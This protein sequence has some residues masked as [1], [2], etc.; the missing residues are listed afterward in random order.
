MAKIKWFEEQKAAKQTAI[1]NAVKLTESEW[2]CKLDTALDTEVEKRVE[3][4]IY[5]KN[6]RFVSVKERKRF[7]LCIMQQRYYSL[8]FSIGTV[9]IP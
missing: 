1:D 7:V 5:L 4:G 3:E 9:M 6:L 2:Q 8:I